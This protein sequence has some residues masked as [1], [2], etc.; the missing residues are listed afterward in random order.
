VIGSLVAGSSIVGIGVDAVDIARFRETLVRT[1]SMRGRLF[2]VDELTYVDGMSDPA[3]SLA[4]RFAVREAVM[5]AMELGIG[6]FDFHDVEVRREESGAPRLTL[7]GRAAEHAAARG[8][9]S[10]H[11]TLTHS[12]S[13]AIAWVV[14]VGPG[15][16]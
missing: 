5:K 7:S 15:S 11:V 2:T 12:D 4:V 3:P 9:A 13:T 10:W 8:I 16:A 14:A 6:S 1:P